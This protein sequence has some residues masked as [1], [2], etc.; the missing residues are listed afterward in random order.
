MPMRLGLPRDNLYMKAS[1]RPIIVICELQ[2]VE[3]RPLH[4]DIQVRAILLHTAAALLIPHQIGEHGIVINF[5]D[6]RG[7]SYSATFLP[8]V[9]AEQ[10]R[11]RKLPEISC[12]THSCN[13]L[14]YTRSSAG[15]AGDIILVKLLRVAKTDTRI[16]HTHR[17]CVEFGPCSR[18][19]LLD[20]FTILAGPLSPFP[21]VLQG[22][23]NG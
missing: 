15:C 4:A 5:T 23:R 11:R 17:Q 22:G 16:C 13:V 9:A 18:R 21:V 8:E 10:G 7:L 1:R 20:L 19:W 2:R 14:R 3:I 6:D 12:L